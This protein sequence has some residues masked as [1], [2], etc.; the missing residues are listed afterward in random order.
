MPL[1][2]IPDPLTLAATLKAL[3]EPNRLRIFNLLMEGVQCNCE[4]GDRLQ[5][6]PNLISHHLSVLRRAG[7]VTVARDEHDPRWVYYA[8]NQP[9]L[10]ALNRV[11]E[12]FFDPARIQPRHPSCGPQGTLHPL[13]AL[14]SAAG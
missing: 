7:L 8:I 2:P 9:A 14:T 1:T 6:A 11:F 3:A 4:L 12:T 5:M 10:E 13:A